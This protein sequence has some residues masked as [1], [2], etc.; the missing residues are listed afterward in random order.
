VG[1]RNTTNSDSVVLTQ[2]ERLSSM[3]SVYG[4]VKKEALIF[5]ALLLVS[6]LIVS[7]SSGKAE[8]AKPSV[9]PV[10]VGAVV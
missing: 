2:I 6:V 9:I 7:C 5:G 3:N 8:K 1:H 10:S 4:F